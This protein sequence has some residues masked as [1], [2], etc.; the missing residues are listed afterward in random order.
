MISEES[1]FFNLFFIMFSKMCLREEIIMRDFL[2][3]LKSP[4]YISETIHLYE[5]PYSYLRLSGAMRSKQC[6]M[7]ATAEKICPACK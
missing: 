4:N 6:P 5:V 3:Y 2:S 1:I 7:G